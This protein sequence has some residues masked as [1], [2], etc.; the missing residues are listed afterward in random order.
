MIL[1]QS[2]QVSYRLSGRL[3]EGGEVDLL[4]RQFGRP[5]FHPTCALSVVVYA[6]GVVGDMYLT[7]QGTSVNPAKALANFEKSWLKPR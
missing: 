6:A 5:C 7:G 3:I 4:V 1:H 2:G